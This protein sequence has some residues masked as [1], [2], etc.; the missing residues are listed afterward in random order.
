MPK[1]VLFFH[2]LYNCTWQEG[3]N[4]WQYISHERKHVPVFFFFQKQPQDAFY[5]KGVLRSFTKFMG[6]HLCQ[7]L[8]FNK[9]SGLALLKKRLWCRCFP[10]NFVK[11]LRTIS[12]TEHLWTADCFF[13][14]GVIVLLTF[15]KCL[16]ILQIF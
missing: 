2:C 15:L 4:L 16:R 1:W 7:S 3:N 12:F 9:V 10:A 11:F 8:F 13:S 5:E 6:K 14:I